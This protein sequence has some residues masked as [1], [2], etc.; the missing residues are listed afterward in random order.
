MKTQKPRKPKVSPLDKK[1]EVHS[2]YGSPTYASPRESK[3][4]K[5]IF[6]NKLIQN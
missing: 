1:E 5:I 3:D 2:G 6:K 4:Q